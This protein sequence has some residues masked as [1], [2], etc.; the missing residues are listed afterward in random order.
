MRQP[1]PDRADTLLNCADSSQFHLKTQCS[2]K[3]MKMVEFGNESIVNYCIFT[4]K[5]ARKPIAVM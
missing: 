3:Y 1:T 5:I 2:K 4:P